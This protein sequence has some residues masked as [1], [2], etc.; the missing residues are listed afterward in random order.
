MMTK[1]L[2]LMQTDT[3]HPPV[4]EVS[5]GVVG[6]QTTTVWKT[7]LE[8]KLETLE[9]IDL[10]HTGDCELALAKEDQ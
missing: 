7:S 2:F 5:S 9:E 1:S 4:G 10:I 8:H 3:S 6:P